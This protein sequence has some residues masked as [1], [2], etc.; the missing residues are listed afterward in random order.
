MRAPVQEFRVN[1]DFGRFVL[2]FV[3]LLVMFFLVTMLLGGIFTTTA[4]GGVLVGLAATAVLVLVLK[5]KYD[6]MVAGTVVRFSPSGVELEDALGFR[7]SLAWP[8][9]TRVGRVE[10]R[11]ASPRK[12][13]RPGG[14][15]VRAGATEA[16]GLI[17]W[18]E[19]VVPRRVPG[20][21]RARL[22]EAPVDP[23]T[24]RPQVAIP[25][26]EL[27]PAWQE[28]EMGAWVARHR[29]DLLPVSA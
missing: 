8:D 22:A 18:G 10:T 5:V 28:G 27:D 6:R 4:I 17:G 26:G 7:V 19:R 25:L 24:G 11:M 21:M 29:P 3:A 9:I 16:L 13:G 15:R 23:R 14:M 20:W 1:R 12:V 2:P